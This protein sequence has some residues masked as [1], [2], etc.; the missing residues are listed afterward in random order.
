MT[1]I[2]TTEIPKTF[3]MTMEEM[4]DYLARCE[5]EVSGERQMLKRRVQGIGYH[6][7]LTD[8]D[9]AHPVT[10]N[11]DYALVLLAVDGPGN[12]DRAI[13]I[14]RQLLALQDVV[15]ESK[16]YGIWPWFVDEPL[17]RMNPPDWNWAAFCGLRIILALMKFGNDLPADLV[18]SLKVALGHATR[19]IIR[20]NMGPHYTNI[21][22]MSAHVTLGAGDILNEPAYVEYGRTLLGK[23]VESV[24]YHGNFNE[25][26]SPN[27]TTLLLQLC[28][29]ILETTTDAASLEAAEKL[30]RFTWKS[31]ADYFHPATSQWAGPQSR[32]YGSWLRPNEVYEI[33]SRLEFDFP[34]YAKDK[35]NPEPSLIRRNHCP[36]DLAER[37]KK[38][39]AENI[40]LKSRYWRR[41]NDADSVYGTTWF[42][43]QA[44]M[45]SV[46]QGF[47]WTQAR[48]L[49]AYW[50]DKGNAPAQL[51]LRFLH[52]GQDFVSA[53]STNHQHK[54]RVLTAISFLNNGGDTHPIF[55]KPKDAEFEATDLRLRYELLGEGAEGVECSDGRYE[56]RA[57]PVR[58][59]I[60]PLAG[61]FGTTKVE[62]KLGKTEGGVV[63]DAICHHGEKRTIPFLEL[64]RAY[65][66]AGLELL[67][68]GAQNP[69]PGKA[70]E[71]P[72]D[73]KTRLEWGTGNDP[74][75]VTFSTIPHPQPF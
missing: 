29:A 34:C 47:L 68:D 35:Q 11:F 73:G 44:C 7:R 69:A 2:N 72:M 48:P 21:A 37:F 9:F 62:W 20:R 24:E 75:R 40:E 25:Y 15:D 46:N 19:S 27:Y 14:L 63:L 52:D 64:E 18:D 5:P 41:E 59:L 13:T 36:A 57:G 55:Y 60:Q 3:G 1:L 74:L 26:N 33:V 70:Q 49:L 16:T 31:I 22:F 6:T 12:R 71:S 10:Q 8:N 50:A 4:R 17:E 56:L 61:V 54:S 38:L 32:S 28:D 39:P 66:A 45:G 51:R 67:N 53:W 23:I 30:R 65:L 42:S 43:S 58:A